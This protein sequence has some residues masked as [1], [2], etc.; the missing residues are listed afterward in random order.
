MELSDEQKK[1]ILEEEQRRIAEE[2]YRTQVRLDLESR[3]GNTN[4]VPT[5]SS[6]LKFVLTASGIVAV[7][8]VGILIGV[9]RQSSDQV[10]SGPSKAAS[11]AQNI[12]TEQLEKPSPTTPAKLTTAQI[13]DRATPSVVVVENINEDG[14]KSGQ[15]S[16]YVFSG[17]G[18]VITNY[19]VIRGAKSLNVRT[20]GQEPYRVDSVLAYEIDHDI[21]AL[22]LMGG[23]IPALLTETIEEPKVGDKVVAIGAPLGLES[24]VSEGIV[25]ALRDVGTMHIIQTTASISPGSS[26]GPLLN[27]YGKVIGLTTSTVRDGQSLNF[28]VSAKHVSEL[29]SRRQ[30]M[31]LEEMLNQT[32]VSEPLA[33]ST[34][35][36]PARNAMQL[37]FA[38]NGQQGAVLEGTYTIAGGTGRD[39]GVLLAG[40]GGSVIV[41]SG[42]VSGFG[43]FKQRLPRGKYTILFDN[44]FSSFSSKS[45]SPDLKLMYYK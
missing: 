3:N 27:E 22:Q 19:H 18:I 11:G 20:Q 34:I 36:V 32:Q 33:S 25:S 12:A 39:V 17:D 14:E 6:A 29:L 24:T 41:N 9:R 44:R 1:R 2:K 42:R 30:P 15:G 23:S 45:V 7:L 16:G 4:P 43:Q 21:A 5:K 13:A 28:V 35:M 10:T 37:S 31:S 40:P 8:C 26:G 38:V